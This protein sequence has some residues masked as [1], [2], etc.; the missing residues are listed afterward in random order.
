MSNK[1]P[2][3]YSLPFKILSLVTV[4]TM[5]GFGAVI[6]R[7]IEVERANII[8]ERVKASELITGPILHSIYDEMQSGRADLARRLIA[9]LK[10]IPGVE[11]IQVIRKNG[12]DEAFQD[13]KTL[14][15]VEARI[16]G[17]KSEWVEDHP[18]R[19]DVTAVGIEDPGYKEAINA[20]EAGDGDSRYY[21]EKADPSIFTHISRI[22]SRPACAACHGTETGTRAY[23]MISTS[24]A[25]PYM[26]L[27]ESRTR[28]LIYGSAIILILSALF[29]VL[30]RAILSMRIESMVAVV[31]EWG[32]GSLTAR[33]KV[34]GNDELATL[35][36][37]F[38]DLATTTIAHQREV[39]ELYE[40]VE[41][42][43]VQ[44]EKT[45]DSMKDLVA[46]TDTSG[47]VLRTNLELACRV[48]AEIKDLVGMNIADIFGGE[49]KET[50]S[51]C[52]GEVKRTGAAVSKQIDAPRTVGNLWM[53]SS[54]LTLDS[55][56]QV[57]TI[58][59]V[60][61]DVTA[62]KRLTRIEEE[63]KGLEE[64]NRFKSNLIASVSHDLR[65]PLTSIMGYTD[66][67]TKREVDKETMNKWLTIIGHE[68]SRLNSFLNE[69]LDLSKIE[70]GALILDN[71]FF[72]FAELV[73]ET[74]ETFVHIAELHSFSITPTGDEVKTRVYGDKTKLTNVVANML[75]N[76]V[77]YSPGGGR[78]ILAITSND[79]YVKLSVSDEGIG[80]EGDELTKIF[81]PFHGSM[82]AKERAISSTGLGLSISLA[83]VELHGGRLFAESDGPDKGATFYLTVPLDTE[84]RRRSEKNSHS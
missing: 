8:T 25:E 12:R 23:L 79:K 77:K 66:L 20:F 33:M 6:Y 48:D 1:R 11:R 69:L 26:Q 37:S 10:T 75:D 81:E 50:L 65:T 71:A 9:G 16:G 57:E 68:C 46:I 32:T 39:M 43:K 42:A 7:V 45:F 53:T 63:K 60:M 14:T 51:M 44:W 76:A 83:V 52:I 36:R 56:G 49:G 74:A 21:I 41:R 24:L 34:D 29:F 19:A 13:F 31:G 17:L 72:D 28:W 78:I 62:L 64:T 4:V 58:L 70:T 35:A 82:V 27:R 47:K 67:M 54:Q 2:L 61:T 5:A 73:R 22:E 15:S 40:D 38:N 59:H 18:R 30:L 3:R 80:I 55:E 84:Q